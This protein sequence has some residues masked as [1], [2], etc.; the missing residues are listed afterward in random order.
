MIASTDVIR[1]AIAAFF[2]QTLASSCKLPYF[3]HLLR[4]Y[5]I[6]YDKVMYY[7]TFTAKQAMNQIRTYREI[8]AKAINDFFQGHFVD[9]EMPFLLALVLQ[10]TNKP[11]DILKT[12]VSIRND[13]PARA[14]R[15]WATEIDRRVATGTIS[16]DKLDKEI[17]ALKNLM[18]KWIGIVD[19]MS[20]SSNV[21]MSIGWG[22]F[23]LNVPAPKPRRPA[24][25]Y[26]PHLIFV[27]RLA[28]ISNH[29]PQFESL[30]HKV[31]GARIGGF[32]GRY[33]NTISEFSR[34]SMNAEG[35]ERRLSP[36]DK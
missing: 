29:T 8:K 5:F 30:I 4:S 23:S 12:A 7:E 22:P 24:F 18:R 2:Y 27:Q 19:S 15:S 14:F 16:L 35:T 33:K 28:Q 20:D 36:L 25:L 26:P 13:D 3:P 31:F 10:N 6:V 11:A 21:R 32:W 1:N 17:A 34:I 9:F